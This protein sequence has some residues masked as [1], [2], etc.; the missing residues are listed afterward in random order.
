MSSYLK[1]SFG[2]LAR[3]DEDAIIFVKESN[4]KELRKFYTG[5][6]KEFYKY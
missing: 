1:Y 6:A 2:K 5:K 3:T 4:I